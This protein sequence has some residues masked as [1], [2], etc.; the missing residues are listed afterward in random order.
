MTP[1]AYSPRFDDA[2]AYAIDSFRHTWRKGTGIPY[3]T[4]L[5]AVTALVGE[6][7]GDEDQLIAAVL[8]DTLED[9][10]GATE[11][12]LAERFGP[13]V[14]RLVRA[15]SDSTT[16]PK[17]PWRSRKEAYLAHLR[18]APAEVKLVSAADKLHNCSTIVRDHR[19]VGD[20]VFERFTGR[21]DGTLWYYRQV[22]VALS[23]GWDSPLL[24]ELR[25]SVAELHQA[26]GASL[27]E[28]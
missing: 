8:H 4:H 25:R 23:H 13:R 3:I 12:S 1:S 15:L 21:R 2:V 5:L 22:V 6:H 17:P 7:G 18:D 19:Q 10:R 24:D 16:H 11:A 27:D 14:A 20:A 26:T 9:V 28:A